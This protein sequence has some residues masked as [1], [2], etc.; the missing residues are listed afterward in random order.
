MTQIHFRPLAANFRP[1]AGNIF[2]GIIFGRIMN[3]TRRMRNVEISRL[4]RGLASAATMT[5]L[6]W[7]ARGAPGELAPAFL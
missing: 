5:Q 1:L 3:H 7:E 4:P 6:R 2:S